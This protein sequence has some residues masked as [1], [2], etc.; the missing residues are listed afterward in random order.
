MLKAPLF[1]MTV[2]RALHHNPIP[3][4]AIPTGFSAI[5]SSILPP[6]P[7]YLHPKALKKFSPWEIGGSG[8][9]EGFS[10]SQF[11]FFNSPPL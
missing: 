7:P 4:I 9:R 3:T 1:C 11:E 8:Q 2:A 6:L 5:I 10:L